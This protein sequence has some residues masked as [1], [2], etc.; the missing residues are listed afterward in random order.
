V[1]TDEQLT[2]I[3]DRLASIEKNVERLLK[4]LDK[5]A[6]LLDRIASGNG[7]V[8]RIVSRGTAPSN[9]PTFGQKRTTPQ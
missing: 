1:P 2:A 9:V 8:G 4:V 7:L 5:F 3:H 6:P